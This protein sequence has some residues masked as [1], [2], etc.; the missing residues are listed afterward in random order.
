MNDNPASEF[1]DWLIEGP[2]GKWP[3][4]WEGKELSV[5]QK[6]IVE[7]NAKLLLGKRGHWD[8][9]VER[10]IRHIIGAEFRVPDEVKRW[11]RIA[12]HARTYCI[13]FDG[14]DFG[15]NAD[16]TIDLRG[17]T[18]PCSV[19]FIDTVFADNEVNFSEASFRGGDVS[20]DRMRATGGNIAFENAQFANG[21]V[22]FDSAEFEDCDICFDFAHFDCGALIFQNAKFV[23][24][25]LGFDSTNFFDSRVVFGGASF[26]SPSEEFSRINFCNSTFGKQEIDF[27]TASFEHCWLNFSG[28]KL[29]TGGMAFTPLN[30]ISTEVDFTDLSCLGNFVVSGSFP[31]NTSFRR[32][33]VGGS[34]I[35]HQCEFEKIPDFRDAKF[36]RPPEVAGMQVPLPA[37]ERH[38][39]ISLAANDD[40]VAKYRKLKAM[41]IAASDHERDGYF[42]AREMAAKRGIEKTDRFELAID[43][44]YAVLSFYG[45]SIKRPICGFG[46]SLFGFSLV[47]SF[48]LLSALPLGN[49][50]SFAFYYSLRN[51]FPF[52]NTLFR[53]A[54]EPT[55]ENYKS[56]FQAALDRVYEQSPAAYEIIDFVA[57][58][59][60]LIGIVLLFLLLL[61]LRNKFKMQ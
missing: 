28:V 8:N 33:S 16:R 52:V 31:R 30:L 38:G 41:A 9:K 47:Y 55:D 4:P 1:E 37:M 20:F 25:L 43:S 50:P 7:R 53:F 29:D 24:E 54:P 49:S 13:R 23:T 36:E 14:F 40:D 17:Y 58:F 5:E 42:F 45:Q 61:G 10:F 35:F 27:R 26:T 46:I 59:Q 19:S 2:A 51:T 6:A 56:W 48:I 11:K 32:L 34:A 3:E 15:K 39:I 18:F 22:F 57:F 60:Q 21:D 12:S 44:I